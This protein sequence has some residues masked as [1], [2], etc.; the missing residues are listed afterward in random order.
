MLK[1]KEHGLTSFAF[2]SLV[3]HC[4]STYF[5]S[6]VITFT[7]FGLELPWAMLL[8]LYGLSGSL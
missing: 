6:Q 2:I 5:S 8:P 3:F 1:R 4:Q 7:E